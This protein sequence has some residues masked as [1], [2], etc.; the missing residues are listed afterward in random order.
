MMA[1]NPEL[2]GKYT[3]VR[4]LG[5][6]SY[7]VVYEAVHNEL[8][9][10]VAVKRLHPHQAMGEPLER[11]KREAQICARLD[12]PHIV[13]VHDFGEDQKGPFLVMDLLRGR[14]L[15]EAL[16]EGDKLPVEMVVTIARQVLSA[17]SAAHRAGVVHRDIKPANIFLV[18]SPLGVVVKVL[19]FGIAKL[20]EAAPLTRAGDM[21]GTINYMSPEQALASEVDERSDI[22]ALGVCMYIALT[23]KRPFT[24]NNVHETIAAIEMGICKEITFYRR[25]LPAGLA[26]LVHKA[27]ALQPAQRFQTAEEM[28]DALAPYVPARAEGAERSPSQSGVKPISGN[29]A[30]EGSARV[31]IKPP[32][33][34]SFTL[35]RPPSQT[36]LVVGVI[37]GFLL[38]AALVFAVTKLLTD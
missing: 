38:A 20:R 26:D 28:I 21:V 36:K 25:D 14:T 22:Y 17:L 13:G 32:P 19:D 31:S 24:R 7:G 6:G 3:V 12:N 4:T 37:V 33:A 27:F 15:A 2:G 10:T 35:D 9:R 1:A 5:E 34:D 30:P 16:H 18:H 29:R 23:G 8:G 11:F